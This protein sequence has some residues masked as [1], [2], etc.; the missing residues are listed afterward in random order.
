MGILV[1]G[2]VLFGTVL[3]RYF[4]V[5]ILVPAC[6]LAIVLILAKPLPADHTF[7]YSLLEIVVL[8]TSLQFGYAIGLVSGNIP[9]LFSAFRK[10]LGHHAPTAPSRSIHV[11]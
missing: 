2:G 1:I 3:G 5:F 6:V 11:R 9:V 4:K 7:L 8:V 10:V